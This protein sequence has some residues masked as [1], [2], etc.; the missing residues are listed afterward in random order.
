VTRL[1][2]LWL[3]LVASC[4]AAGCAG[5]SST[6]I[7]T[8]R[9][10]TRAERGPG[11]PPF[12]RAVQLADG[13]LP[14]GRVIRLRAIR[15]DAGACLLIAGIDSRTRG[16]G[17]VA[18]GRRPADR[19]PVLAEATVTRRGADHLEIFAATSARVARVRLIV[20]GAA[21]APEQSVLLRADD[22]AA[23]NRAGITSG[24]FAYFYAELPRRSDRIRAIAFDADG[25]RIGA[26][27]F[28]H[29][30]RMGELFILG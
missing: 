11:A 13:T 25:D 23:L 28:D 14:D 7:R 24:P 19:R 6:S 20:G 10:V 5:E 1:R 27:R 30:A 3:P 26:T 21:L 16:C 22:G 4:V 17:R 2:N 18:R 12:P 29:L 9:E 8:Q 15:D